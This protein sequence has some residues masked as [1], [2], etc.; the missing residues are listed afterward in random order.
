MFQNFC[1]AYV[2][3]TSKSYLFFQKST[4]GMTEDQFE[5]IEDRLDDFRSD[6]LESLLSNINPMVFQKN[7]KDLLVR[8]Y[9]VLSTFLEKSLSTTKNFASSPKT[10][11]AKN[12]KLLSNCCRFPSQ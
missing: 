4:A 2:S 5:A 1:C 10:K 9:S 12:S 3:V 6:N 11:K 7:L 8:F